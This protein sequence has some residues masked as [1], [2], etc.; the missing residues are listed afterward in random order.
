MKIYNSKAELMAA[1]TE[2]LVELVMYQNCI[3]NIQEI[4]TFLK[5]QSI[6]NKIKKCQCCSEFCCIKYPMFK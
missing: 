2:E 3:L 6:K 5:P 1:T 4:Q